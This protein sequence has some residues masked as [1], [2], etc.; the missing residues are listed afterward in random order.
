MEAVA[1]GGKP[2]TEEPHLAGGE[3]VGVLGFRGDLDRE[4]LV[5]REFDRTGRR[6]EGQPE[7]AR[8]V[9]VEADARTLA[10]RRDRVTGGPAPSVSPSSGWSIQSTV[11]RC[12]IVADRLN[13]AELS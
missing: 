10:G 8:A 2:P 3:E 7:G 5:H 9:G 1:R 4:C 12:W 11:E 6:S 13:Q